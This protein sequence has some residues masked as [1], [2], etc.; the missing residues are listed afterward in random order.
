MKFRLVENLNEEY[1]KEKIRIANK[2][3]RTS[4]ASAINKDGTMRSIVGN[5]VLNNIPKD[6]TILDF[7]AGKDAVQTQ[8]LKDNGFTNITAYDFGDNVKEG[9][10]DPKAL[11]KKYDVVFASNVLNVSSDEDMLR[12]TLR[13]I[14]KASKQT[15]IFN[16]PS[17]PRKANL[18][19][20]EFLDI[21]EDEYGEQPEIV[22]GTKQAPILRIEK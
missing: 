22:G 20:P 14:W 6:L 8:I 1:D 18:S 19:T 9:I 7:G 5:Y 17:S 4:G 16:Y 2:T 3:S 15:I 10:H 13:E 21:V 11:T 12:E